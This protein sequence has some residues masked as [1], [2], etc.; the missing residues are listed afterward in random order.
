MI[1]QSFLVVAH[2][3]QI[4]RVATK[5]RAKTAMIINNEQIETL[6]SA[7]EI[8]FQQFFVRTNVNKYKHINDDGEKIDCV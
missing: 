1:Q 4:E 3:S 6:N 8:I 2:D 5:Q 7:L